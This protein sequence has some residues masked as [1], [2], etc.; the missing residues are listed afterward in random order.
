MRKLARGVNAAF[1]GIGASLIIL[2]TVFDGSSLKNMGLGFFILS[3]ALYA[4]GKRLR[5][6]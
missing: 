2:G 3:I 1:F 5:L 6:I 4:L